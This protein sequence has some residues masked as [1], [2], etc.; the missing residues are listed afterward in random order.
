MVRAGDLEGFSFPVEGGTARVT[1]FADW[2]SEQYVTVVVEEPN[3]QTH[4]SVR[5]TGLVRAAYE[6]SVQDGDQGGA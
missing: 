4:A 1:G 5:P 2:A 3:G 6:R